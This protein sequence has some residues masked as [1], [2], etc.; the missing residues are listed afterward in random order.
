MLY[1]LDENSHPMKWFTS[2]MPMTEKD[3]NYGTA[4]EDIKCNKS[5]K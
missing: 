5:T 3:N 2:I 1:N 4:K